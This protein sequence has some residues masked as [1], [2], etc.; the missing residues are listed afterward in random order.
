MDQRE[1]GAATVVIHIRSVQCAP[2]RRCRCRNQ[3]SARPASAHIPRDGNV[4]PTAATTSRAPSRN[5]NPAGSWSGRSATSS[6][7]RERLAKKSAARGRSV[8]LAANASASAIVNAA[9]RHKRR[10]HNRSNS[11]HHGRNISGSNS[12][13]RAGRRHNQ[14][15]NKRRELVVGGA[16]AV[17]A[18]R[19]RSSNHR[20]GSNNSSNHHG[21]LDLNVPPEVRLLRLRERRARAN[22]AG[23]DAG[24]AVAA[25]GAVV[26]A[27]ALHKVRRHGKQTLLVERQGGAT[28]NGAVSAGGRAA[29]ASGFATAASA[30][31]AG[32]GRLS[33]R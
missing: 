20:R 22:A 13:S 12:R 28:R 30:F 18:A 31:V 3:S 16:D 7:G 4:A 5:S 11:N 9:S 14:A 15:P 2:I 8:P 27:A 32:R 19:E 33:R 21:R 29:Q 10:D 25:A 17:A 23:F 26:R 6:S 1:Q 24:I